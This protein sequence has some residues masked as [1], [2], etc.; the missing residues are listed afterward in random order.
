MITSL[1]CG[2]LHLGSGRD[3]MNL[4]PGRDAVSIRGRQSGNGVD[5][6]IRCYDGVRRAKVILRWCR[7]G[8]RGPGHDCGGYRQHKYAHL[9]GSLLVFPFDEMA[10]V[11]APALFMPGGKGQRFDVDQR[12]TVELTIL[13]QNFLWTA[14][15]SRPPICEMQQTRLVLQA[16]RD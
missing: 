15:C 11:S 16:F 10:V 6:V 7:D 14:N 1:T 13:D 2:V 3:S 8:A 4:Q 5:E 9:H 12:T